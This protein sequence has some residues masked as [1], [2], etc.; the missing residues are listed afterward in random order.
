MKDTEHGIKID[1]HVHSPA[2]IDYMGNKS[3]LGYAELVKA[4][5]DEDVGAIAIT[6]HN[7]I[8]GYLEYRR[9]VEDSRETYR[10]MAARDDN[11]SVVK[12]LK[13]EVVRFERLRVFP[14]V[15]ITVYPNIHVILVFDDS[16]VPRVTGFLEND[17][18]LGDAVQHGDPKKGSKQSVVAMLDL[19]TTR[20]G[21][22][23]FCILPHVETSKGAW[24][25]LQGSARV[26]LF[27]D[28]RVVA[29][30]FSNPDTI[31]YISKALANGAYKRK[32]PL[33]FIQ[34]SDYHGDPNIKPASQFSVLTKDKPR[35]FD[36]LRN[37]L[38]DSTCI[39][40]SHEFV[41]E[42]LAEFLKDRPQVMFEF[43]N[44]LEI[45]VARRKDLARALCGILNSGNAV[46]RVNLFNV[47]DANKGGAEPISNLFQD[48]QNDLDPNDGFR[49]TIS[50]FHQSTSRQRYCISIERN[51][52]LRLLDGICWVVDGPTRYPL[53]LGVLNKL[54][55]R[56]ITP[57]LEKASKRHLN[58]RQQT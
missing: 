2:S 18:E 4:F 8:N 15:E 9:Q 10:L 38:A 47:P 28:E 35:D 57:G 30:Q 51:V 40:C 54:L 53:Q 5:V 21:D 58:Q 36:A 42:R 49:F 41:E 55:R 20:F 19:A 17:L 1:L 16:V 29:A 7:T 25:E 24:D 32:S 3:A 44:K 33:A 43:T 11:S 27:R 12:D 13:C 45:D 50:Q 37:A 26:D 6:D 34:C 39:R 52:K 48:L 56:L 14:G 23:F 46:I 31:E 22:R